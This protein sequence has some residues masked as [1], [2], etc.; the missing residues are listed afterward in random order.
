MLTSSWRVGGRNIKSG[1]FTASGRTKTG[2]SSTSPEETKIR[3][4]PA[5]NKPPGASE[6]ALPP[7]HRLGSRQTLSKGSSKT[8]KTK[9]K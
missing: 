4:L 7:Q 2:I 5:E 9:K 8:A 1:R 6:S 3:V